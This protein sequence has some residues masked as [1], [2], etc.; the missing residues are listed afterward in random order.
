MMSPILAK[1]ERTRSCLDLM[2]HDLQLFILKNLS[3]SFSLTYVVAKST[4]E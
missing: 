2:G 3:G 4:F 1:F